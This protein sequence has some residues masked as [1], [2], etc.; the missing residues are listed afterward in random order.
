MF[1]TLPVFHSTLAFC[2]GSLVFVICCTFCSGL[3]GDNGPQ[4]SEGR[5]AMIVIVIEHKVQKK[6]GVPW[7]D[8]AIKNYVSHSQKFGCL[9]LSLQGLNLEILD[10]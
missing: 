9:K 2:A 4:K 1:I 8:F 10:R 3:L 7:E 6:K 5:I